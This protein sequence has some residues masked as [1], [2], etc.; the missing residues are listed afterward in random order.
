MARPPDSTPEQLAAFGRALDEEL[1]S[2]GLSQ[3]DLRRQLEPLTG[4]A[5]HQTTVS[6]WVGGK[7]EPSRAQVAA[8]EQILDVPPG[9]LARLLGYVPAGAVPARN[10]VEAI[11]ADLDLSPEQREDLIAQY[12]LMRERTLARRLRLPQPSEP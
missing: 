3:A 4:A 12:E 11:E 1:R 5:V 6:N 2:R 8:V 9:H 7:H 10:V